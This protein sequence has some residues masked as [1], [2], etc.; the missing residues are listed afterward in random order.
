[1]QCYDLHLHQIT[2][3]QLSSDCCSTKVKV[4][5]PP[6]FYPWSMDPILK[7]MTLEKLRFAIMTC[8]GLLRSAQLC[9]VRW[10]YTFCSSYYS[11][12]GQGLTFCFSYEDTEQHKELRYEFKSKLFPNSFVNEI[13]ESERSLTSPNLMLIFHPIPSE[14]LRQETLKK[15]GR[16]YRRDGDSVG[17]R[18][19]TLELAFAPFHS[20]NNLNTFMIIM[21]L[22]LDTVLHSCI[23]HDCEWPH[24]WWNRVLAHNDKKI[25]HTYSYTISHEHALAL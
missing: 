11:V 25:P 24:S 5:S 12:F 9:L 18:E 16:K 13:D 10:R 21:S 4:C 17:L 19:L 6:Q 20:G 23:K 1:M 22:V 8:N 7:S 15:K 3:L 2:V 14:A